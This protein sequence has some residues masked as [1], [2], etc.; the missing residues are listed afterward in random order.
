M[1]LEEK[2]RVVVRFLERCN[3]Y[4]DREIAARRAELEH[5]RGR[6]ALELADEIAHW[7]AY[8]AFNEH[9]IAELATPRLDD[10]LE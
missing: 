10:W 7:A 2:K 5:A 9:A 4:A 6:R 1:S 8:R 3:G